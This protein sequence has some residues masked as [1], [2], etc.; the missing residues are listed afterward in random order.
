[1]K[2]VNKQRA[3]YYHAILEMLRE[4][5]PETAVS[6]KV[7]KEA[8]GQKDYTGRPITRNLILETM[9]FYEIPIGSNG[10]GYFIIRTEAEKNEYLQHL[11]EKIA[12]WDRRINAV[13]ETYANPG[14]FYIACFP[15]NEN[16]NNL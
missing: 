12:G 15:L 8:L 16:L 6:S 14:N 1:M 9:E 11:K 13:K 10:N 5:T 3:Y 4:A 7:I 2:N